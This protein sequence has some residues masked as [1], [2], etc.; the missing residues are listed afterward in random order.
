VQRAR[1][2]EVT[3]RKAVRIAVAA[4]RRELRVITFDAQMHEHFGATYPQALMAS[5]RSI[6]LKAAI[7][8]LTA[9][10]GR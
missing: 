2:S 10:K 5:K 7:E 9:V 4:M 8:T 6:E 3:H 1:P